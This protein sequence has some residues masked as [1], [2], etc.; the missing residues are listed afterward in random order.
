MKPFGSRQE[1]QEMI[2]RLSE[3]KMQDEIQKIMGFMWTRVSRKQLKKDLPKQKFHE[4]EVP[5]DNIQ[6]EIYAIIRSKLNKNLSGRTASFVKKMRRARVIRLLQVV[7]NP[8]LIVENDPVHSSLAPKITKDS[9]ENIRILNLIQRYHKNQ[10]SNKIKK[11][12]ELARSLSN[13][14]KNVVIFTHFRGNVKI[15]GKILK[16]KNPLRITGAITKSEEQEGIIEEFKKSKSKKDA[17]KIL[18][19]TSGTIAESVS[20][21]KNNETNELVCNNAIFLERSYDA[22]KYMQA[23]HRI[24]RIGSP[25]NKPVNYYIFKSIFNDNRNTIDHTIDG[26][27]DR[28]KDRLEELVDDIKK[29][30]I[31]SLDTKTIGGEEQFYTEGDDEDEIIKKIEAEEKKNMRK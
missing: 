19:A 22:G 3:K 21:H 5:M 4:I 9:R 16:D 27:L 1:F 29:L 6:E 25:K 28:R 24:F 18:I 26:I 2:E 11:A 10:V 30:R 15:L 13:D 20:L 8:R 14:G 31:I 17:G 23:L 7:T 12:A